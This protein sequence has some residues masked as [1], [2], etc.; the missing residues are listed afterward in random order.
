MATG[1]GDALRRL[2]DGPDPLQ[3]DRDRDGVGDA[4]DPCPDRDGDGLQMRV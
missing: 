4:C 3:A 1:L 2:S